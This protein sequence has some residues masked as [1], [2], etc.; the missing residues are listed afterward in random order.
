M[1][2]NIDQ[3][4]VS[5]LRTLLSENT[6]LRKK[7]RLAGI[8]DLSVQADVQSCGSIRYEELENELKVSGIMLAE[9][10]WNGTL[11]SYPEIETM[12]RNYNKYLG[13]MAM[14]TEHGR[15]EEYD[16]K[17]VGT[18]TKVDL[19]PRLRAIEYEAVID[20]EDACKDIREGRFRAT[21]MKIGM[22]KIKD[23]MLDKGTEFRPIDNSLTANPA[24]NVCQMFTIEQMSS[25][26]EV[27]DRP[28]VFYGMF[29][30]LNKSCGCDV[31]ED[32][33]CEPK[34]EAKEPK[35]EENTTNEITTDDEVE[36]KEL[37]QKRCKFCGTLSETLTEHLQ[38]CKVYKDTSTKAL[39][40]WIEKHGYPYP[41]YKEEKPEPVE[42][43]S[44]ETDKGGEDLSESETEKPV[45]QPEAKPEEKPE[46][47]PVETPVEETKPTETIEEKPTEQPQPSAKPEPKPEPKPP[48]LEEKKEEEKPI[49]SP[50]EK[51]VEKPVEVT[52][53]KPTE[54]PTQP[55]DTRQNINDID[56]SKMS[57]SDLL[58][59]AAQLA[60]LAKSKV[61]E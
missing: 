14:V 35:V 19:N 55:E 1:S 4:D 18:H 51:P 21:S 10:V 60:V 22:R 38:E 46:E 31:K 25:M 8:E 43:Q 20:D 34:E 41:F 7:L 5:L 52:T 13:N 57:A 17:T 30:S 12:Y 11:Y 24:C 23:G 6:Q 50:P 2:E 49:E 32:C 58:D 56:Y 3:E 16:Y 36:D 59:L 27:G 45:E 15:D 42:E 39:T 26:E 40:A 53:E 28:L 54:A 48:V 47:K 33:D 37:R 44:E 9:G 29:E 61:V